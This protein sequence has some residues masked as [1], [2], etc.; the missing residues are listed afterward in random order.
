MGQTE[1]STRA[2]EVKSGMKTADVSVGCDRASL[3]PLK[4]ENHH[5]ASVDL[6]MGTP[7]PRLPDIPAFTE[8]PEN[9]IF[10]FPP[11]LEIQIFY[12]TILDN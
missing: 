3:A 8:L 11:K 1:M 4:G 10:Y 6:P 12:V 9:S 5:P 2:T 7:H